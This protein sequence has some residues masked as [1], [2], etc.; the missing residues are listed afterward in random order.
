MKASE[1]RALGYGDWLKYTAMIVVVV[2]AF[3]ILKKKLKG[4][5]WHDFWT[6]LKNIESA[7]IA[8]AVLLTAVNFVVLTGYD[9]IAV[10]YLKKDLPVSKIMAGA[11][12][13]YSLSNIFGWIFGGTAVRY[14]MYSNWGFRLFEI[15]ALLTILSLTFW[16]GMFMLAGI[17]FV[18]LPV[19]LPEH[20]ADFALFSPF[21]WGWIFLGVVVAYLLAC[22]FIRHPVR[23]KNQAFALPPIQMSLMQLIVSAMEFMLASAVLFV[24]LP[25]HLVNFSTVLVSYMVGM[26]AVVAVHAPGGIGILEAVILGILVHDDENPETRPLKISVVCGMAMY[27][28]IYYILPGIFG[29]IMYIAH[30]IYYRKRRPHEQPLDAD[31]E[32]EISPV[33][34]DAA[35]LIAHPERPP[36]SEPLDPHVP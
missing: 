5:G 1:K 32:D 25:A 36:H 18:A 21:V 26:V 13:G 10:R 15:A 22:L 35:E 27:R 12:V 17:A 14:R 7:K 3:F 31:E 20:F 33:I 29:G 16:L 8:L 28:V 2:I 9:W 4:I 34:Q 30:E 23:W 24:L 6:G 11:I 19:H